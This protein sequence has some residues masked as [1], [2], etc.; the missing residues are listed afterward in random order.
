[1][2]KDVGMTTAQKNKEARRME[3]GSIFALYI[4][5]ISNISNLKENIKRLHDS[6]D[7]TKECFKVF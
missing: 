5:N 3:M 2:K 6:V 7:V 4:Q 1:M